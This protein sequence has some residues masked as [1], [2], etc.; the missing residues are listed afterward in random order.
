LEVDFEVAGKMF[1]IKARGA[2]KALNF[3]EAI[4]F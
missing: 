4:K 1:K 3:W 2:A